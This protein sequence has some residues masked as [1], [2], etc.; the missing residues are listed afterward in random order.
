MPYFQ[1][2]WTEEIIE[3]LAEHGI[4]QADFEQV[5]CHPQSKG[6]SRSTGL[7]FGGTRRMDAI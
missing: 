4:S 6:L 1:F 7:Q 5:V 2:I 3:H